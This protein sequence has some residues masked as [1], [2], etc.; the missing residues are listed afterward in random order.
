MSLKACVL[1]R[2]LPFYRRDSFVAGLKACGYRITGSEDTSSPD[3][4]LVIW[5]RYSR[6]DL[7]AQRYERAGCKVLVAENGYLGRDWRGQHWYALARTAHNGAGN[8][9]IGN[10]SRWDDLRVDLAPWR[11]SGKEVVILATRHIGV[12]GVA[13]PFGWS[14]NVLQLIRGA[15]HKARIRA[16]PGELKCIPLDKDLENA[17]AVVSWGSGGA[18]KALLWGIPAVYGFDKWIGKDAATRL[19]V[20]L[21]GGRNLLADRLGMFRKLAWAMWTTDE[22]ATGGPFAC[23][24]EQ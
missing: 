20:F 14:E 24:L 22:L 18:L 13:E 12:R 10:E 1:I 21:K 7:V 11:D 8:W 15:G 23:V 6:F 17:K 16:H 19:E 9:K 4:I 3:N 2:D 5:N